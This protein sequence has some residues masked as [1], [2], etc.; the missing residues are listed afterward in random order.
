[1]GTMA[2]KAYF[3]VWYHNAHEYWSKVSKFMWSLGGGVFHLDLNLLVYHHYVRQYR[4][5]KVVEIYDIAPPQALDSV[6]I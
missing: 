1:M 2:L 3:C 5:G 4:V 6:P